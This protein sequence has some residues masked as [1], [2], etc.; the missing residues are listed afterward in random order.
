MWD[1]VAFSEASNITNLPE[2]TFCSE[3]GEFLECSDDVRLDLF[4]G[5]LG[6]GENDTMEVFIVTEVNTTR[7]TVFL[8][9]I[10][11]LECEDPECNEK[12]VRAI[13]R[14]GDSTEA[15]VLIAENQTR[16]F[17]TRG[18]LEFADAS[19]ELARAITLEVR[20]GTLVINGEFQSIDALKPTYVSKSF[21]IFDGIVFGTITVLS[22]AAVGWTRYFWNHRIVMLSQRGFLL[23]ICAG[24]ALSSLLIPILSIPSDMAC[25]ARIWIYAPASGLL[26]VAISAKLWRAHKV[27]NNRFLKLRDGLISR[28]VKAF[29]VVLAFDFFVLTVFTLHDPL[30]LQVFHSAVPGEFVYACGSTYGGVYIA[31]IVVLHLF[32]LLFGLRQAIKDR[33]LSP[34]VSEARQMRYL[35]TFTI[36]PPL[37]LIPMMFLW[38]GNPDASNLTVTI[39][40][41]MNL[42]LILGVVFMPKM[43]HMH[44][45]RTREIRQ[46]GSNLAISLDS[47]SRDTQYSANSSNSRRSR[48]A[49]SKSSHISNAGGFEVFARSD[50][51]MEWDAF[52]FRASNAGPVPAPPGD[53]DAEFYN[54]EDDEEFEFGL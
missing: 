50:A 32:V 28:I 52:A 45:Y 16:A 8:S 33:D 6:R 1:P 44:W 17:I 40:F 25:Q 9:E 2:M 54:K 48:R 11:L 12:R 49:T 41:G 30:R 43:M 47:G 29:A 39:I 36:F 15:E 37:V 31:L 22:F 35:I 19:L 46:Q 4:A 14:N 5:I 24:V 21:R 26:F 38:T 13:N 7:D 20:G 3:K 10:A 53:V 18:S 34:I 23:A 51:R 27:F 42:L